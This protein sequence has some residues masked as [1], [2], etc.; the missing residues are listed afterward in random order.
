LPEPAGARA[1]ELDSVA[2]TGTHCLA[3]GLYEDASG[4]VLALTERWSGGRWH[5]LPSASTTAP[6]TMLDGVACRTPVF[7]MAVGE[8]E[9][10]RQ[11]PIAEVWEN[12]RWQFVHGGRLADGTL[13]GVSCPTTEW[14]LAVGSVGNRALTERWRGQRWQVLT[15]PLASAYRANE[16]STLSCR[17]PLRCVTVGLRYEPEQAAKAATLA[18]WW[19]GRSW[20]V[21]ATRNP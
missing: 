3:V 13:R 11:R 16:L 9:W 19:N 15:T 14:C 1:S 17:T 4:R 8:T 12:G 10:V 5:L 21:M 7:C 2:C 18:E 6:I 20:R